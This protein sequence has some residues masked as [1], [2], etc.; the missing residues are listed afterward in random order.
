MPD[1]MNSLRATLEEQPADVIAEISPKDTMHKRGPRGYERAGQMALRSV[2][3]AMLAAGKARLESILDFGCGHGRMLRALQAG[4]PSASLAACDINRDGVDFCARTFGAT[5]VY[6]STNP[7]EI[8]IDGTFDLIWCNSFFTHVDREGWDRF[9][10]FLGSLLAPDGIFI[11]TTAGRAPVEL[12]RHSPARWGLKWMVRDDGIRTG[13][14][15]D[16]DGDGFAH[17]SSHSPGWGYTAASPAWVCARLQE[18]T[19]LRL[20]GAAEGRNVDTFSCIRA[21]GWG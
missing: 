10:P 4:F 3:L 5:P 6:S 11:F 14:L 21:G 12:L 8:S 7:A 15:A 9:L 19:T 18:V 16:Y 13:F 1:T 2:R 20:L 17:R